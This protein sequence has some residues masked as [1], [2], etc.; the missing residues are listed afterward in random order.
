MPD[1]LNR[2]WRN[3]TGWQFSPGVIGMVKRAGGG[4]SALCFNR[5]RDVKPFHDASLRH[6]PGDE[7]DRLT[8]RVCATATEFFT[9]TWTSSFPRESTFIQTVLA[10][11]A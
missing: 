8:V 4:L 5:K 11:Q 3:E 7:C 2:A 10:K 1:Q 9:D 6:E